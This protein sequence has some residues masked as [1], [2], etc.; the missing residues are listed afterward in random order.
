MDILLI[1]TLALNLIL[2]L[3]LLFRSGK[4]VS[5][6]YSARF[7][8]ILEGT[9][10]LEQSIREELKTGREESNRQLRENR[11]ELSAVVNK[12]REELTG[13]LNKQRDE[14][15]QQLSQLRSE[16]T[17]AQ[18]TFRTEISANQKDLAIN[19][20]R[21]Q[22]NLLLSTEKKLEEMR[23]TVDEKLQKT[24]NERISQSFQLVS[25]QLES[26]QNGLG[27]MKNLATDVSGLKKV[28]S[29]VK[30]RG[31][32]GEVQ[33]G[34]LLEQMLSPEQYATNVKT[35]KSGNEV[36]EFAV[37]LPGRATRD[38]PV[39]LPIDAKFP[40]DIYEQ[41]T[42][43][44]DAG[45][46]VLILSTS[47]QLEATIKKMAKDIHDKYIDP[48]FTTDFAILFLPFENIYAEI[49]RRTELMEY[50]Q[51]HL[52]IIVTGPTTLG[53]ILNSLQM[54]F[55]TLAI[56]KRSSEVWQI[57]NVVKKEFGNFGTL[58]DKVQVNLRKAGDDLEQVRG[59]RTRAI[60]RSLNKVE[61]LPAEEEA[62][63]A[64]LN[65]SEE[66]NEIVSDT[67]E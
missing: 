17:Q 47:K 41:F 4:S 16:L 7:D 24:L 40:K 39:Y 44:Y 57:L 43:A 34:A 3:I 20:E 54:G 46:T 10:R 15:S 22:E 36:V 61:R 31:T 11:E 45:D 55:K 58:L 66:L 48:P 67:H 2:L 13:I 19:M 21:K 1:S 52:K 6:D 27:E 5:K 9:D 26:V 50:L 59:V 14:L 32:F 35:R 12:Q 42:D 33:L 64:P 29:N 18:T 53:A 38:K 63:L 49:I 23:A 8:K 30:V 65:L 37:K 25:K 60:E 28:L 51:R 56:Q 62:L